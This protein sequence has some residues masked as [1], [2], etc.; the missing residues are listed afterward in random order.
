VDGQSAGSAPVELLLRAGK[1]LVE[2][3]AGDRLVY[4]REIELEPDASLSFIVPPGE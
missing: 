1:R 3:R 4:R 2:V